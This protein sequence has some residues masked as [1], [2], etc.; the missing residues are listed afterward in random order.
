MPEHPTQ[1]REEEVGRTH[2]TRHGSTVM[3]RSSWNTPQAGW[4]TSMV[5][6][7]PPHIGSTTTSPGRIVA[8]LEKVTET[9]TRLLA[10]TRLLEFTRVYYKFTT[11]S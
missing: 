2:R 9:I 6:D 7:P 3:F 8:S 5:I 11:N 1:Q 4:L 10:F